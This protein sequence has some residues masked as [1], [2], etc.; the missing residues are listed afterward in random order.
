MFRLCRM[1]NKEWMMNVVNSEVQKRRVLQV[2]NSTVQHHDDRVY[3]SQRNVKNDQA[4]R[5]FPLNCL[6][7]LEFISQNVV[8][9]I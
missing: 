3:L 9:N 1:C 2:G 6:E 5:S 8:A 7:N 4:W